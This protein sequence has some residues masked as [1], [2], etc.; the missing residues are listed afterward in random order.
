MA[1]WH[2]RTQAKWSKSNPGYWAA[3]RLAA[4]AEAIESTQSSTSDPPAV[5]QPPPAEIAKVPWDT[6]Q[7]AFGV[8]GAVIIAFF[9]RLLHRATQE[10][11]A[12][13]RVEKTT[14]SMRLQSDR[15]Q[16]AMAP[17]PSAE[18]GTGRP[19]QE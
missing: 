5:A 2:K 18:Q 10:A 1:E 11:I 17:R 4:K 15:A 12:T 16:E 14:E 7:E 13:Q 19:F 8:Q 3:R 6:V 9:V